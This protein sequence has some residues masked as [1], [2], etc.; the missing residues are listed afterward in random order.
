MS[1][2]FLDNGKKYIATIY[3]DADNAHW[4]ENPEAYTIEK[5]IVDNKTNL[6]LNLAAGGGAAV[7]LMLAN[8]AEVKSIK[9]YK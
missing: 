7:S 6:L 9:G 4:K 2:S 5:F 8:A 3:R 1:L